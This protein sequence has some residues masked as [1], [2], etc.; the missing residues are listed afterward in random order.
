MP[1]I[2]QKRKGNIRKSGAISLQ[3]KNQLKE[4]DNLQGTIPLDLSINGH[5]LVNTNIKFDDSSSN[6]VFGQNYAIKNISEGLPLSDSFYGNIVSTPNTVGTVFSKNSIISQKFLKDERRK[7]RLNI[8]FNPYKEENQINFDKNNEFYV[9]GTSPLISDNFQQ[10]I[11]SREKIEIPISG[12]DYDGVTFDFD[13]S[14]NAVKNN[15]SFTE[16]YANFLSYYNF[17]ENN[18]TKYRGFYDDS[19]HSS[20]TGST[21]ADFE[22][23]RSNAYSNPEKLNIAFSPSS[24]SR[25]SV[26]KSARFV[27]G[28]LSEP[29]PNF[30]FP[31]SEQYNPFDE[32]LL[33]MSDYIDKPF[34]LEKIIF[35]CTV[36]F[37]ISIQK[38]TNPD[39]RIPFPYTQGVNLFVLNQRNIN[40]KRDINN[41]GPFNRRSR[42][43]NCKTIFWSKIYKSTQCNI[44][45]KHRRYINSTYISSRKWRRNIH[46]V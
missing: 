35:K 26:S 37:I 7:E 23:I 3:P 29:M 21:Q 9:S 38:T 2:R 17:K 10:S 6:Y 36:K 31:F 1:L 43:S 32:N 11:L 27:S 34:F 46:L 25:P 45:Y 19:L 4:I 40:S 22:F 8:D 42:N 41:K 5:K 14:V 16:A 12:I 33:K 30:G 18:W 44:L 15:H 39:L 13:K 28:S 24:F 20:I